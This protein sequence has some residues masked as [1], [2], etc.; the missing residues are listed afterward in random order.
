[1]RR[2]LT[3]SKKDFWDDMADVVVEKEDFL[4]IEGVI[5]VVADREM[6]AE[7][8]V[9]QKLL[10]PAA[11]RP[12]ILLKTCAI[13]SKWNSGVLDTGSITFPGAGNW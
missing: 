7:D 4:G 11:P 3:A 9:A 10:Y 5:D 12:A 1:V 2:S 8:E 6:G 13:V